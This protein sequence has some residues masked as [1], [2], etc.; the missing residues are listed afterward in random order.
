MHTFVCIS[1]I[2]YAHVRV[3]IIVK[4]R[5]KPSQ[6]KEDNKM[7]KATELA[8]Y[9]RAIARYPHL[10][11]IKPAKAFC[12]VLCSL[13]AVDTISIQEYWE[14]GKIAEGRTDK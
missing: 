8:I 2:E 9:E 11:T 6:T 4:E 14:I 5:D 13:E 12:K 1:N 7:M 10:A 3:Y